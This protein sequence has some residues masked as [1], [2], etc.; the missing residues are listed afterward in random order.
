[1]ERYER[2]THVRCNLRTGRTHQI[3][4]HMAYIHHPLLGDTL[5][6]GRA[7]KGLDSQCLHARRLKFLHPRSGQELALECPLPPYF[8][9]VLRRLGPV[10]QEE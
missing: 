8:T 1:M 6:G 3:R 5:Y 9:A 4:V 2:Y 10:C 7:D